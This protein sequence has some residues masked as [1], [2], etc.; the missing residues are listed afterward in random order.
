MNKVDRIIL[1]RPDLVTLKTEDAQRELEGKPSRFAIAMPVDITVANSGTWE[2]LENGNQLW[3]QQILAPGAY[4]LNFG[5]TKYKMPPDSTLYIYDEAGTL[6][7]GPFTEKH[8][9][10]HSQLWTPVVPGASAIIELMIPE[11]QIPNLEI[12]LT[13]V[14]YGYKSVGE[15]CGGQAAYC[16]VD[17][18]CDQA[19]NWRDEIRSV[20]LLQINGELLC[21]GYLVNNLQGLDI[22]YFL[23]ASHCFENIWDYVDTVVVYWNYER[24]ICDGEDVALPEDYTMG[25]QVVSAVP[26]YTHCDFVLLELDETPDPSYGVY[27]AGI[28]AESTNPVGEVVAIH[29]PMCDEKSIS[30]AP[31]CSAVNIY[32]HV[33]YWDAGITEGGSSGSPL[34][35]SEHRVVGH[36][37]QGWSS[38]D[39][40]TNDDFGKMSRY[41]TGSGTA[42]SRLYDHLGD[43]NNPD[44]RFV[45]GRDPNHQ[46]LPT[47]TPTPS[48]AE[49]KPK[50]G[51]AGLLDSYAIECGGN[52]YSRER[53]IA[54]VIPSH[55]GSNVNTVWRT[56]FPSD[57]EQYPG[58]HYSLTWDENT[59]FF[60]E[61]NPDLSPVPTASYNPNKPMAA[62]D[63]DNRSSLHWPWLDIQPEG[64]A[65]NPPQNRESP[66]D[67][68]VQPI[69]EDAITNLINI[70]AAPGDQPIIWMAGWLDTTLVTGETGELNILL[71]ATAG[72]SNTIERIDSGDANGDLLFELNDSNAEEF[73]QGPVYESDE[74]QWYYWRGDFL[75]EQIQPSLFTLWVTDSEGRQSE[76]W[77]YVKAKQ[78][79]PLSSPV[80]VSHE[81]TDDSCTVKWEQSNALAVK[82]YEISW[83]DVSDG[84]PITATVSGWNNMEYTILNLT[85]CHKYII[86]V[87]SFPLSYPDCGAHSGYSEP[88]E[89]FATDKDIP[90]NVYLELEPDQ[91]IKIKWDIHQPWHE[92]IIYASENLPEFEEYD[93]VQITEAIQPGAPAEYFALSVVSD[94]WGEGCMTEPYPCCHYSPPPD[95]IH[96]KIGHLNSDGI[97]DVVGLTMRNVL[98]VY[99][100][101]GEGIYYPED[102]I[103]VVPGVIAFKLS[104]LTGRDVQDIICITNKMVRIISADEDD[105]LTYQ[106]I[107]LQ[108]GLWAF[109]IADLDNDGDLDVV[110]GSSIGA[111]ILINDGTGVL[112]HSI[113]L[114][115]QNTKLI[116]V[117]DL[118]NDGAAEVITN[119]PNGNTVLWDNDG[120][121]NLSDSGQD[122]DS[123]CNETITLEDRNRDGCL[124]IVFSD[125]S[126][127]EIFYNDCLGNFSDEVPPTP[128]PTSTPT[129]YAGPDFYV[130]GTDGNDTVGDGSPG[131]PWRTITH[132]IETIT[133]SVSDPLTIHPGAGIYD[134]GQIIMDSYESLIGVG[135]DQTEITSNAAWG[136]L[137]TGDHTRV[138]G[139]Y[140]TNTY[141]DALVPKFN[142]VVRNCKITSASIAVYVSSG[143]NLLFE[144]NTIILNNNHS[145]IECW[146]SSD[147]TIR[148]NVI[149]GNGVHGILLADSADVEITNNLVTENVSRG[150]STFST[151]IVTIA[152]NTIHS[153][154]NDGITCY[155]GASPVITNNIIVLNGDYGINCQSGANPNISYNNIWG[156]VLDNYNGCVPSFADISF[157]PLFVTGPLGDFYLSRIDS[158]QVID[159]PCVDAGD[160]GAPVNGTTRTDHLPD[161]GIADMGYHYLP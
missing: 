115:S 122:I 83:Y 61:L 10:D 111:P 158:G 154:G 120:S 25:S 75:P 100:G 88:V 108:G 116:A 48:P 84:A 105:R 71:I 130:D 113:T 77:P 79:I 60:V 67:P 14:N 51:L 47:P 54:Y 43:P 117:G 156:N 12:Q 4:T 102:G 81:F 85:K 137:I 161:Y 28:D 15:D 35:D 2:Q 5:F 145:G 17:V 27:Y 56:N 118:N 19:D 65:G 98:K 38:C 26:D 142:S 45:P 96:V 106:D 121:G 57:P 7:R 114:L 76:K 148:N 37:I 49:D 152:F 13:S 29:H 104:G 133:G 153:N 101:S 129:P 141:H 74:F 94:K 139:I 128:T 127:E 64:L 140:I 59:N 73:Q 41:W 55:S 16:N 58:L 89:G 110:A 131:N 155:N 40:P 92:Y 42:E 30:F 22:P 124:D 24:T 39:D 21:S 78:Y 95:L 82:E 62:I 150:I 109:D 90:Y 99:F 3:R 93:R 63:N 32:W 36:C 157:D 20:G 160:P 46:P 97:W 132:T 144:N 112:S 126:C 33:D 66:L 149:T 103:E 52:V 136:T 1:S 151:G 134:E 9:K 87:R 91:P 123:I 68:V 86:I 125:S 34:F 135:P 107:T 23:S 53:A 138:E 8:N 72:N 80:I 70:G 146:G 31:E 69:L 143:A 159:S 119:N 6:I 50:I 147:V 11:N 44:I 18:I